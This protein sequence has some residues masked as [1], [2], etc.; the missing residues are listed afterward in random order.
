[1]CIKGVLQYIDG[2]LLLTYLWRRSVKET[3]NA[4]CF[5]AL[6]ECQNKANGGK[7]RLRDLLSVPMQRVL[8]YPL[9]L[10]VWSCIL[11]FLLLVT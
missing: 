10:R 7:F 4:L 11:I 6:Q 9:L 1:M 5:L 8:K 3:L 2:I